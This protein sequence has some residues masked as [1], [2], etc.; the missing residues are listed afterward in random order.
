MVIRWN[1]CL[2][3]AC[4]GLCLSCNYLLFLVLVIEVGDAKDDDTETKC[5]AGWCYDVIWFCVL[6][7]VGRNIY[8][9]QCA[10]SYSAP[11]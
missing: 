2:M 6:I 11:T 4:V 7:R 8:A 1:S 5:I 3:H 9:T 10:G